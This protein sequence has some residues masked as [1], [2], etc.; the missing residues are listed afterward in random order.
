MK[1]KTG[2]VDNSLLFLEFIKSYGFDPS[3]YNNILELYQSP[4]TSMSQ[5]LKYY[6]QFLLS[7]KIKE[8]ELDRIGINGAYGYIDMNT[9]VMPNNEIKVPLLNDFDVIISNG[10][11]P[12]M[13]YLQSTTQDKFIGLCVSDNDPELQYKLNSFCTLAC[14]L[15]NYGKYQVHFER[16][17]KDNIMSKFNHMFRL[18]EN[19]SSYRVYESGD[20]KARI[21]FVVIN[22]N[23]K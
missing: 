9:I 5:Y 20:N 17:R 10:V 2:D 7:D 8:K 18:S 13:S 11:L 4:Q 3:K 15:K 12:S 19:G 16:K 22:S 23:G 14:E 1:R 21:D 6:K